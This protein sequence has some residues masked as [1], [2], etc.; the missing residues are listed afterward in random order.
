MAEERGFE[1][2]HGIVDSLWLKKEGATPKEYS[3]LCQEISKEIGVHI[4]VEG[5]YR[6]IVFLP[7]KTHA[8]VPVLNRY[9]GVFENGRIKMRGIE[10]RRRD[11]PALIRDAQIDMIKALAKAPNSRAFMKRIPEAVK[12]LKGYAEKLI[13]GDVSV[14]DLLIAKQLSYHPSDYVHDVFQAIAAK[15]LLQEGVEVSA[16]QTVR[17]LITNAASR[18]ADRRVK[19]AELLGTD[20]HYDVKKY[21]EF[22]LTAAAN[23]LSPFGYTLDKLYSLALYGEDQVKLN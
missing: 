12:V 17:Y 11:T 3:E 20:M 19:A 15:Q 8:E 5:R 2:V 1:V 9:F 13:R 21:L 4:S 7:S 18:R 23:I 14:R 16:G 6:W 22:L 10:A